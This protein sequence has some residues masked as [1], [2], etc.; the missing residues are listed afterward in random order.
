[1]QACKNK[2]VKETGPMVRVTTILGPSKKDEKISSP[3]D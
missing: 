2:V 1:M 3:S